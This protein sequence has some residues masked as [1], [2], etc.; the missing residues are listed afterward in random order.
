[1]GGGWWG[2]GVDFLSYKKNVK[3]FR[4]EGNLIATIRNY[5]FNK[6]K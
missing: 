3:T 4:C 1:V 2:M 6:K 5:K